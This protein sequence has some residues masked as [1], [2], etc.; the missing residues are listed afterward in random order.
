MADSTPPEKPVLADR[1]KVPAEQLSD[2]V[3]TLR[4]WQVEDAQKL[5]AAAEPSVAELKA[6][7]PW[8]ANGYTL[9]DAETFLSITTVDWDKGR[10]FDF[11]IVANDKVVG[12]C[13]LMSP[14]MGS[15]GMAM[16]YWLSTPATGRGLATKAAAL[17]TQAAFDCGAELVQIWHKVANGKS[18]AIPERLGYRF[19]GQ[20]DNLQ[21]REPGEMGLWQ[22]DKPKA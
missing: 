16:G 3:V 1:Y 9:E 5:F 2:G 21:I 17:L 14:A 13:G 22:K 15:D 6:W 18:R 8:A 12:S 20:Y 7:M 11:A 19:L 4:R 10:G